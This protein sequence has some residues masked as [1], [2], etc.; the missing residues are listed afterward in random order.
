MNPLRMQQIFGNKGVAPKQES[1]YPMYNEFLRSI[2][3]MIHQRRKEAEGRENAALDVE[4]S[5]GNQ[6]QPMPAGPQFP[7]QPP[8]PPPMNVRFDPSGGNNITP[9]QQA[10][11]A[12]RGRALENTEGIADRRMDLAEAG[13]S[14][15]EQ[16]AAQGL[17]RTQQIEQ[18]GKI[19]LNKQ[20]V[21]NTNT[22]ARDLSKE[23]ASNRRQERAAV[24]ATE[25]A[26]LKDAHGVEAAK[27]KAE[28]ERE[29]IGLRGE[30][31]RETKLAPG[32]SDL[33]P[34]P[35]SQERIASLNKA[36]ELINKNP[37]LK[38]FITISGN[39]FVIK[40]SGD[41]VIDERIKTAIYSKDVSL[42]SETTVKTTAA[43]KQEDK[44]PEGAT[45]GG[46]WVT[47]KHGRIYMAP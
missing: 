11:L 33:K 18:T 46:K 41:P 26:N 38:E 4:R 39:G 9:Y 25:L 34:M 36:Q 13:G 35:P 27:V 42:P 1:N 8:E 28:L 21:A 40:P 10:Q 30:E 14:R 7:I 47:T 2:A 37:E 16:I 3:P 19:N 20:D 15:L 12:L 31:S 29:L 44:L 24:I 32:A 22:M 5:V 45:P 43:P 6:A 17:N 23:T